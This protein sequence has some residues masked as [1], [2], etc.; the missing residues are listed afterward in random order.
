MAGEATF[1]KPEAQPGLGSGA[2]THTWGSGTALLFAGEKTER[3]EMLKGSEAQAPQGKAKAKWRVRH[4]QTPITPSKAGARA[5]SSTP[6]AVP[7]LMS[8]PNPARGI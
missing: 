5:F 4:A 6:D 8:A 1:Q 2:G 7:D 3:D